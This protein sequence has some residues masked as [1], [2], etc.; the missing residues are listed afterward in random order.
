[1]KTYAQTAGNRRWYVVPNKARMKV[2]WAKGSP[3]SEEKETN[4]VKVKLLAGAVEAQLRITK[5]IDAADIV[6]AHG[7]PTFT[8]CIS[9]EDVLGGRHTWYRTVE[10]T[11]GSAQASG[12]TQTPGSTQVAGGTQTP[13]STQ[14]SGGTQTPGGTRASDSTQTTAG[15]TSLSVLL[16][17]PAGWYTVSEEKTMRYRLQS[18]HSLENGILSGETA[19]FDVSG[20]QTGSAVFYNQ[21]T[22]DE[23]ESHSAFVKNEIKK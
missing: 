4:E 5:E 9:G 17:V 3:S 18:I 11:P 15:K 20:G 14:A 7:N 8:F 12:G 22:T 10:F 6:W 19:V 1:M 21:K 2:V 16:T 23:K 13:G